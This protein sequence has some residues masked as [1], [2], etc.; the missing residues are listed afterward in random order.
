MR[1]LV[2]LLIFLFNLF[3]VNQTTLLSFKG[4]EVVCLEEH[5]PS[6]NSNINFSKRKTNTLDLALNIILDLRL[7]IFMAITSL[8]LIF[9]S[10]C[11]TPNLNY[12]L[13]AP[14]LIIN[15]F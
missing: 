1:F 10:V 3:F 12:Y 5:I 4:V 7:I 14:P 15:L 9:R 13:R 2:V 11:Y 6:N 8:F